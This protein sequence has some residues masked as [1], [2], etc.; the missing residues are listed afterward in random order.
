MAATAASPTATSQA[1]SPSTAARVPSSATSAKVRTPAL[2]AGL[3]SR[4]SPISNPMPR[5]A[6]NGIRLSYKL[7]RLLPGLAQADRR[8]RQV[9]DAREQVL[10]VALAHAG[11]RVA[12]AG[13]GRVDHLPI[14]GFEVALGERQQLV[15]FLAHVL[16]VELVVGLDRGLEL[17]RA[18]R[19]GVLEEQQGA[20]QLADQAGAAH[21]LGLQLLDQ[22][23]RLRRALREAREQVLV[24]LRVVQALR[25]LVDVAQHGAEHLEVRAVAHVLRVLR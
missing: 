9:G 21:V 17:A 6:P 24:L 1:S 20:L 23:A 12:V 19:P 14:F 4:S 7:C 5:L 16:P 25:V 3:R 15:L 13:E 18:A 22:R 2:A 8:R 11:D 10:E